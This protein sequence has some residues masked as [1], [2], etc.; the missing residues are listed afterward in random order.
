MGRRKISRIVYLAVALLAVV[1]AGCLLVAV[2]AAAGGA[3][4]GYVWL[5]G[6]LSQD[7]PANLATALAASRAGLANLQL[8]ILAEGT[9]RG[10]AELTSRTPDHSKVRIYLEEIPDR[11][12][13]GVPTVRITVRVGLTGDR[14][15]SEKILGQIAAHIPPPG[16]VPVPAVPPVTI[17]APPPQPT[18]ASGPPETKAPPLA[19]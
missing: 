10:T 12:S 11:L 17:P 1:N 6:R 3:A 9:S 13:L 5:N 8:P 18:A 2:G 19:K 16:A 15:V 14:V 4:I 7:Y